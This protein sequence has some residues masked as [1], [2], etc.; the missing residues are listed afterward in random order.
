ML[1]QEF[2]RSSLKKVLFTIEK[3]NEKEIADK[4][5]Y[6]ALANGLGAKI[7]Y[8]KNENNKTEYIDSFDEV[9]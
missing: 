8:L 1:E 6:I 7:L 3:L 5:F 9:L 4:N 2:W